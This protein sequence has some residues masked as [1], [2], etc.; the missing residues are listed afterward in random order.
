[1]NI[2]ETIEAVTKNRIEPFHSQ[3]LAD[4]L[5]ESLGSDR[6]L[7]DGVWALVAPEG[8]EKPEFADMV[9]VSCEAAVEG[10]RVDILICCKS[11]GDR[12]VG[13]EV[14][15][16]EDS[17]EQGQLNRYR[18][19]LEKKFP[20][21]QVQVAY[22]TPFNK[23][24]AGDDADSLPTV[25]EFERLRKECPGASH[26]SW[27]EV[28]EIAW[29]GNDLWEQHR[30]YVHRRISSLEQRR[31]SVSQDR[32]LAWFFGDGAA[33]R[34]WEK[35]NTLNVRTEGNRAFIDFSEQGDPAE[36]AKVLVEALE[37]LI[38]S[39]KVVRWGHS[40]D[41]RQELRQRF[42][43]SEYEAIHRA[44]FRLANCFDWV[45]V[46][47][48]NDY[49]VRTTRRGHYSGVSLITSRGTDRLFI[50]RKR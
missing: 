40:D 23:K 35:L 36:V 37:Q 48:T 33:R 21:S 50:Q 29:D 15:T 17:T 7:F 34:F 2:F 3:F 14:K 11:P 45:W 25:K 5:T 6:S 30:S 9:E 47:G 28:A 12:V 20:C 46:Q 43:G 18:T 42:L 8:W 10:G 4:A 19:G 27:L 41:F 26:V 49:G 22:L 1:M 38:S 39:D 13:I 31:R 32:D 44:L 16:V 24:R